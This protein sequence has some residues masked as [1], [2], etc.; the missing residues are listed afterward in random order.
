MALFKKNVSEKTT[1]KKEDQKPSISSI[2]AQERE[3]KKAAK[4][5]EFQRMLDEE[6]KETEKR[7]EN[8]ALVSAYE[9]AH[10]KEEKVAPKDIFLSAQHL[11][12]IYSNRVQA[13]SDLSIDIKKGEFIVMV[14][15][16]GCGKST[17]LRMLAGLEDI[18]SGDLYI[19]GVYANGLAPIDRGV[20]MVFQSYALYP[21]MSVYDNMAFGLEGMKVKEPLLDQEGKPILDKKGQPA[22]KKRRLSKEEI[23]ERIQD[24]AKKLQITEYL[25]RKPTQLSGGQCQRVA[26]GRAVVRNAKIFL[27]DEPLSN[28]DAKLRVQMRS[29][30]VRL[31]EELNNTMVYVTHDQTEAM[32]MASRIIVLNR[33]KVQQIGTPHEV[34]DSPANVF[35]ATFMGSP[36][37]NILSAKIDQGEILFPDG[38]KSGLS[39]KQ[40][41]DFKVYFEARKSFLDQDLRRLNAISENDRKTLLYSVQG[42]VDE[43][44]KEVAEVEGILA[45]NKGDVYFGIRPED[46]RFSKTETTPIKVKIEVSEL[47]GAEYSLHFQLSGKEAVARVSADEAIKAGDEGYLSFRNE[48][49]HLFDHLTQKRI[50]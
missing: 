41:S 4:R 42:L 36:T 48:Q 30:L 9:K 10:K 15:P 17:T 46:M 49:I 8:Y 11:N 32:T 31:H 14:G 25:Q 19:D 29:E 22:F 5:A 45:T 35:V 2:E 28:L 47:L 50:F 7:N 26:L 37:M 6:K 44:R 33:G 21:H 40:R 24:A 43:E 16:S 3:A 23:D 1:P 20:A 38:Q 27:L 12:K 39:S 34:Y 18:T 13:V